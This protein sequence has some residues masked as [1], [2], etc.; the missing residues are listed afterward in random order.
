MTRRSE[1][2]LSNDAQMS[3]PTVPLRPARGM[4]VACVVLLLSAAG[5]GSL[6]EPVGNYGRN[7]GDAGLDY[8]GVRILGGLFE[9]AGSRVTTWSYL[10]DQLSHYDV[11]VWAPDAM[12]LPEPKV[13]EFFDHWLAGGSNRT[14]V[15]IGRDYDASIDYWERMLKSAAADQRVG[16]LRHLAELRATHF[17][18]IHAVPELRSNEWITIKRGASPRAAEKLSGDWG[19]ELDARQA[20]L[21]VTDV[22]SVPT[23][24]EIAKLARSP[25]IISKNATR[26]RPL[27]VADGSVFVE[28]VTNPG[29]GSGRVLFVANGSFLLNLP[30]ARPLPRR[31][32]WRIVQECGSKGKVAILESGPSGPRLLGGKAP[33]TSPV[34][35][36][37][38]VLL[39]FHWLILGILFCL[40]IYPIFGRPKLGRPDDVSRF[41]QHIESLGALLMRSGDVHYARQQIQLYRESRG[42]DD[43]TFVSSRVVSKSPDR[44]DRK[45]SGND[46]VGPGNLIKEPPP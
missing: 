13:M 5:C 21:R 32:A 30:L 34:F 12:G 45:P 9:R 43:K 3:G 14:L 10:S 37:R 18:R 41:D 15:Y 39:A 6:E 31:L 8:N 2:H 1:S 17:Q 7:R 36:R 27:L 29:W 25:S 26:H 38:M 24:S 11:I 22:C 33:E 44:T 28:R 19:A 20:Q 40:S 46:P 23:E 42:R 4:R 35:T 16:I